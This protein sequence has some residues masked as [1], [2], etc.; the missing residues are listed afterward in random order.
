MTLAKETKTTKIVPK[1]I[2]DKVDTDTKENM[3]LE[4]LVIPY[5]E[6]LVAQLQEKN[7]FNFWVFPDRSGF[8]KIN[9][10]G[11][12]EMQKLL[13]EDV[14]KYAN[15]TICRVSMID[16]EESVTSTYY[17]NDIWLGLSIVII[18]L[19]AKCN[20]KGAKVKR[21]RCDV[22]WKTPD[23][24]ITKLTFKLIETLMH[25]MAQNNYNYASLYGYPISYVLE[26]LQKKGHDLSAALI[27]LGGC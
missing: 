6:K 9:N 24:K 18:H 25:I 4:K 22:M 7:L 23:F 27:P 17:Q 16:R 26:D 10:V 1:K 20:F 5:M 12:D 19:D 3:R 13:K 14:D 15:R 21:N 2:K 11:Y 8:S